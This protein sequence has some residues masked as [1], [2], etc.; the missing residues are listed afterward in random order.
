MKAARSASSQARCATSAAGLSRE[1]DPRSLLW[2][3]SSDSLKTALLRLR[4]I[5]GLLRVGAGKKGFSGLQRLMLCGP[6]LVP[7]RMELSKD[8]PGI[9][10]MMLFE[11]WLRM[12]RENSFESSTREVEAPPSVGLAPLETYGKIVRSKWLE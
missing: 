5:L 11:L 8:S 1:R 6:R 9:G 10:G 12:S 4:A 3:E 7:N 2:I